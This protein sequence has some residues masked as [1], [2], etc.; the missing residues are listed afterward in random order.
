MELPKFADI[1]TALEKR[2][3]ASQGGERKSN[4]SHVTATTT[5]TEHNN[6]NK[7]NGKN[8]IYVRTVQITVQITLL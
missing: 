3:N 7:R 8:V 1:R 5:V 4:P 2:V 6:R